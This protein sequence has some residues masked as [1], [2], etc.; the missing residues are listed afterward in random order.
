MTWDWQQHNVI[1][2]PATATHQQRQSSEF[3]KSGSTLIR[4]ALQ[5]LLAAAG[6]GRAVVPVFILEPEDEEGGL[7]L[8]GASKLFRS[9]LAQQIDSR[10]VYYCITSQSNPVS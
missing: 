9:G 10:T 2:N 7:P 3:V 6:S 1:A 8:G 4:C 5:A